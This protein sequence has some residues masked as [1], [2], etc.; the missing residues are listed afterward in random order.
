MD[1]KDDKKKLGDVFAT[2]DGSL[3]LVHPEHGETYHSRA[4]ADAEARLLYIEASGIRAR[5]DSARL[6]AVLDVGLGLGYNALQTIEAWLAHP[7]PVPAHLVSLEVS[8]ELV[9]ALASGSAPWQL[10]WEASRRKLAA[11]LTP[12]EDGN[13]SARFLHPNRH[14][15]LTWRVVTGDAFTQS[16]PIVTSEYDFI[17]QD[18]F[19]PEKNPRMWSVAWFQKIRPAVADDATL[20]TYSVARTVRD[21]L[22]ASE[23]IPERFATADL[24]AESSLIS[25]HKR[26]W[27]RARP[28][29]RG[30]I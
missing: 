7:A 28:R 2:A 25:R 15:A 22:S 5:F 24:G 27:L 10:T 3:T 23:F 29:P 8:R 13:Y 9:A 20:M 26:Q 11:S 6:L 12:E 30:V 16:L 17:W 19:S 21:A 14:A 18:P 1:T 4:G